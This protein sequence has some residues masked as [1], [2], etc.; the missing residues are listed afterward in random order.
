MGKEI[1]KKARE[2]E[3]RDDAG[4]KGNCGEV[5]VARVVSVNSFIHSL[6]HSFFFSSLEKMERIVFSI[7]SPQ[8][9]GWNS[10]ESGDGPTEASAAQERVRIEYTPATH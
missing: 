6:I 10:L 5:R 2:E 4:G 7:A 9:V 3:K 1:R 8:Q